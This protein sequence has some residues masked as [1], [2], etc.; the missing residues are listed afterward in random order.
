[1][2]LTVL[3]D[4]SGNTAVNAQTTQPAAP[5]TTLTA[6]D[7]AVP[8]TASPVNLPAGSTA[9]SLG[10]PPSQITAP[11]S[12]IAA[13][14]SEITAEY[15][16]VSAPSSDITAQSSQITAPSSDITA[17]SSQITAPPQVITA[18]S[19]QI[20]APSAAPS[21]PPN[22]SSRSAGNANANPTRRTSPGEKWT[23]QEMS[24]TTF[25]VKEGHSLYPGDN[26]KHK[27][28][29]H[30]KQVRKRHGFERSDFAVRMWWNR[31]GRPTSGFDERSQNR[32][33][34]KGNLTTC[35]QTSR[36]R[37]AAS[38]A[39]KPPPKRTKSALPVGDAQQPE[40]TQDDDT[41]HASSLL[42]Q[43]TTANFS[44][45]APSAPSQQ[46]VPPMN[47]FAA[48]HQT[49]APGN[50][51]PPMDLLSMYPLLQ[52]ESYGYT[53]QPAN[54]YAA[55]QTYMTT[56]QPIS[57]SSGIP[58]NGPSTE[59]DQYAAPTTSATTGEAS[60]DE[61]INFDLVE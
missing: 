5:T 60:F 55:A 1:M 39:N 23:D 48:E 24:V 2:G 8:P 35:A 31:T 53:A 16:H 37:K 49:Y 58:S 43:T 26:E 19:S 52:G 61:F 59:A 29:A 36:K 13:P 11:P 27:M 33:R 30:I 34:K 7:S 51:F 50:Y 17:Q 15:P 9:P 20:T 40:F 22:I 25:A 54:P 21:A 14:S 45:L 12:Q 4:P 3:N 10:A 32:V 44:S 47:D 6:S 28:W 41:V 56:A 57:T 38:N 46:S 42:P 18:P